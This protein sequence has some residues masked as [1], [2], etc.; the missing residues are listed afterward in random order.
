[1]TI[2]DLIDLLRGLF[3]GA[4]DIFP[5]AFV[6]IYAAL[7]QSG[8]GLESVRIQDVLVALAVCAGAV[9]TL[10]DLKSAE[11]AARLNVGCLSLIC[12]A[13]FMLTLLLGLVA[14][15]SYVLATGSR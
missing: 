7:Q 14:I 8:G 6:R 10:R 1:V 9:T 5:F 2:G 12:Q 3:F 13:L 11:E 4:I 15:F